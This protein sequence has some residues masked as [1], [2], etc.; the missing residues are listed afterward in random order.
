MRF[1][2]FLLALVLASSV[3]ARDTLALEVQAQ[4]EA[5]RAFSVCADCY[6]AS[7]FAHAA[8]QFSLHTGPGRTRE[9]GVYVANPESR[10][11]RH[12]RVSRW[13]DPAFDPLDAPDAVPGSARPALALEVGEGPQALLAGGFYLAEAVEAEGDPQTI[14]VILDGVA[15]FHR[16]LERL[17]AQPVEVNTVVTSEPVSSGFDLVGDGAVSRLRRDFQFG[18]EDY[19]TQRLDSILE[20]LDREVVDA[21]FNIAMGSGLFANRYGITLRFPDGT[22]T[23]AILKASPL[24]GNTQQIAWQFETR[25]RVVNGPGL[26]DGALLVPA[27]FEGYR[28]EGPQA[29]AESIM[30]L[31]DRVGPSMGFQG[32][33]QKTCPADGDCLI[34]C[35]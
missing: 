24:L 23:M 33:C 13:F 27:F 35:D 26:G 32:E 10:I 16:A 19:F 5:L 14:E 3:H 20:P 17:L 28:Y 34:V 29:I 21:F 1:C 12:F 9:D 31:A 30:A 8:E 4:A 11:V 2:G 25:P 22:E 7:E 18:L 15:T 6:T